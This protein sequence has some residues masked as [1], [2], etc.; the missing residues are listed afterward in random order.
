MEKIA[1]NAKDSSKMYD[2]LVEGGSSALQR[3]TKDQQTNVDKF[4]SKMGKAIDEK[5]PG[6]TSWLRKHFWGDGKKWIDDSKLAEDLRNAP[7][8]PPSEKLIKAR[9]EQVALSRFEEMHNEGDMLIKKDI[10]TQSTDSLT[11]AAK[12]TDSLAEEKEI[13]ARM[14]SVIERY[15]KEGSEEARKLRKMETPDKEDY[16]ATFTSLKADVEGYDKAVAKVLL[17]GTAQKF[18]KGH[19]RLMGFF[20]ASVIGLSV[21]AR[22]NQAIGNFVAFVPISGINP[23]NTGFTKSVV[24][25]TK[26]SYT[27]DLMHL[28]EMLTQEQFLKML[29][30]YPETF[31]K[32]TGIKAEFLSQGT[33]YL[34]KRVDQIIAQGGNAEE[35]N[36]LRIYISKFA[37]DSAKDAVKEAGARELGEKIAKKAKKEAKREAMTPFVT[38]GTEFDADAG[39]IGLTQEFNIGQVSKWS[40]ELK[41]KGEK[42]DKAAAAL[43]WMITSPLE[44]YGRGD[45]IFKLGTMMHLTKNGISESE[46][47]VL[48]KW[49]KFKSGDIIQSG[50]GVR[51]KLTPEA[52]MEVANELFLNY[53]AMPSWS[54]IARSLPMV[55]A[56]FASFAAGAQ[57]NVLKGIGYNL[58]YFNKARNLIH[59]VSGSKGPMEREALESGYYDNITS[60]PAMVKLPFFKENPVYLNLG[61]ALHVFDSNLLDSP[62]RDY[63]SKYGKEFV[64]LLDKSPFFKDPTG[65]FILNYMVLPRLLGEAIG[66]FNNELYSEDASTGEKVGRS[67]VGLVEPFMPKTPGV[68]LATL[69]VPEEGIPYIPSYSARRLRNAALGKGPTGSNSS[70]SKESKT[71]R[72]VFADMGLPVY[73]VQSNIN[74]KK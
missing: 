1:T 9:K 67:A 15:F 61:N 21:P 55:G 36:K 7:D 50:K 45:Q 54:K 14:E 37:D 73:R 58:S 12:M 62:N 25:A 64:S 70:E 46:M 30:E 2:E 4:I 23:F 65:Q 66:P 13:Q 69:P 27:G 17:N 59:E 3:L 22:V 11:N 8:G 51:F 71:A 40:K 74:P 47:K 52:S 44:D 53:S 24:R 48:Q 19:S 5:K 41:A 16:L 18:F 29:D 56:P 57:K 43:H 6:T 35:A 26:F 68:G 28:K 63:E 60:N 42:G 20:K 10:P 34:N 31:T 72:A 32:I 33:K 49:Y 38:K 39:R